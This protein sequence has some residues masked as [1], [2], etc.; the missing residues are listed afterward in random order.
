MEGDRGRAY[1]DLSHNG[2][3]S[4]QRKRKM[5]RKFGKKYLY[6]QAEASL[7]NHGHC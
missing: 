7:G 1:L 5:I 6:L 3:G 4:Y 2:K